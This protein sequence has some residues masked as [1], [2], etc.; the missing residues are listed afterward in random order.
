[1][2]DEEGL[3]KKWHKKYARLEKRQT[4]NDKQLQKLI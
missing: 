1:M 3:Q 4:K 2:L